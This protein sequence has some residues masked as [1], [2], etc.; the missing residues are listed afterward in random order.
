M[1]DTV[2]TLYSAPAKNLI[3]L[4]QPCCFST[5]SYSFVVPSCYVQKGQLNMGTSFCP[6]RSKESVTEGKYS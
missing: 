4:Q 6:T 3:L 2:E 5:V 1:P